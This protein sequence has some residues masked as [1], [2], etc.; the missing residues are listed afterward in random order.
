MNGSRFGYAPAARQRGISLLVVLILLLVMSVLGI[1][2]LRSSA[3]QERMAANMH[4][5]S[6]S[7]QAAEAALMEAQ[8][9]LDPVVQAADSEVKAA[10]C[11]DM[12]LYATTDSRGEQDCWQPPDVDLKK[13]GPQYRIE[14]VGDV[15]PCGAYHDSGDAEKQNPE[16][17]CP[18]YRVWV[19]TV[20]GIEG[21][22]SVELLAN[23]VGAKPG[24][25]N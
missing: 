17:L 6:R 2:V 16:A 5:R 19:R 20:P 4:D 12:G 11:Q 14:Y 8:R 13:G 1:A 7:F 22:A 25:G 3:M 21:R 18:L 15:A 24:T 9:R 23:V 10:Y